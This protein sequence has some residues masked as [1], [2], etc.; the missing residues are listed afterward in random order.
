MPRAL[1]LDRRRDGAAALLLAMAAF[2]LDRAVRGGAGL[3]GAFGQD[4]TSWGLAAEG[5]ARGLSSPLP[6]AWPA[7]VGLLR[8]A[9][10]PLFTAASLLSGLVAALLAPALLLAARRLGAPLGS[11]L[12]AAGL[13]LLAPDRARWALSWD[14]N[15]LF[16][17]GLLLLCALWA[18]RLGRAGPVGTRDLLPVLLAALLPLVRESALPLLPATLLLIPGLPERRVLAALVL[19]LGFWTS[20]LWVGEAPSAHPLQTPWAA[21]GGTALAD[22]AVG[23]GPLPNYVGE[24]PR[25]ERGAYVEALREGRLHVVALWHLR[26]SLGLAP[27]GWAWLLGVGLVALPRWR[28]EPALRAAILPLAALAPAALLWTQRRHVLVL[29]PA[30]LLCWTLLPRRARLA[31]AL[32][33]L[34]ASLGWPS[35][36]QRLL[37]EAR[38]EARRGAAL[39]E[40]GA[41]VCARQP[42]LLGGPIQDIGL[43]CPRPRHEPD[44]SA[45]DA[46]TV[47]VVPARSAPAWAARGFRP[48]EPEIAG[49]QALAW[50]PDEPR[51]CQEPRLDPTTP[52]LHTEARPARLLECTPPPSPAGA[53][54]EGPP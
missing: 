41:R 13:V 8:R 46:Y 1:A 50:R 21:R 20:P 31:V 44:G 32:A 23:E 40:L 17:L 12:F 16:A 37:E 45:A 5:V 30:A 2:G 52:Y 6:P 3:D 29:L 33:G 51:P 11:A 49:L 35:G 10:L 22:L 27:E 24:I 53:G 7:L 36:W 38:G 39:A 48:V 34:L 4:A 14:S 15:G 42:L 47:L 9:G 43:Y 19:I 26:R 28:A 54:P 25:A 18:G